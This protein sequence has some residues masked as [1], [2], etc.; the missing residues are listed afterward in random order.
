MNV[1]VVC[2]STLE[3]LPPVLTVI[4]TLRKLGNEV[5]VICGRADA[6]TIATLL[7]AGVRVEEVS[8]PAE[9]GRG[10]VAKAREWWHFRTATWNLLKEQK[11][12][13]LLWI[14]SAD[15]A[16]ALG[17]PLLRERYV[18]QINELYDLFPLYR[19]ALRRFA[20]GARHV[21]VPDECR[22]AIFRYWYGLER[23]P[24][25]VPNHP[26]HMPEPSEDDDDVLRGQGV[27]LGLIAGRRLVL[28]QCQ[29][30]RMSLMPI[31]EA[32][33]QLGGG[34]VLGLLGKIHNRDMYNRLKAAYPEVIHFPYIAAPGHLR[35]TRH[36]HVG[37]LLY[38]HESLNNIFC[39]PNKVW[40]YSGSGVP[41]ICNDLPML[42]N[43]LMCH[44]AGETYEIN[45][46]KTIVDSIRRIGDNH[47]A[48]QKGAH[49]LFDS[50]SMEALLGGILSGVEDRE[51]M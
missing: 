7:A 41:M 25:V 48:Y 3:V 18:L 50:V 46:V 45:D 44:H 8:G 26:A 27:D 11:G 13:P 5:S 23:T 9:N 34:Y 6:S 19:H 29:N 32:V 14:G 1:T 24:F 37:I 15:T 10:A 31:A 28:Y 21:V 51:K 12:A 4:H 17:T 38:E 16:L 35:M 22:A 49:S 47:A 30:I 33:K 39:A 36:A 40:E 20:R 43:K 42:A 2:K